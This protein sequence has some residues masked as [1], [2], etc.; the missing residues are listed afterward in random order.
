M[1]IYILG[2]VGSGK[3]TLAKKILSLL[4]SSLLSVEI[5]N[6]LFRQIYENINLRIEYKN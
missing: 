1:K 4:K 6:S 2:P 3:S 5:Y